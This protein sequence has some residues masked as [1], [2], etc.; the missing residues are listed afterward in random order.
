[1]STSLKW[2]LLVAVVLLVAYLWLSG[3]TAATADTTDS[4]GLP[5]PSAVDPNGVP[6]YGGTYDTGGVYTAD[7][8]QPQTVRTNPVTGQPELVPLAPTI[9]GQRDLIPALIGA[10]GGVDAYAGDLTPADQGS[11][12]GWYMTGDGGWYNPGTGEWYSPGSSPPAS[13]NVADLPTFS[14]SDNPIDLGTGDR[15]PTDPNEVIY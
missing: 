15:L 3:S 9:V 8:G 11:Y 4:L 1:M 2:V 6:I 10:W 14:L 7:T 13:V 5:P 12:P